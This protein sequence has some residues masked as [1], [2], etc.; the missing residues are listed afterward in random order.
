MGVA[1]LMIVCFHAYWK[2]AFRPWVFFINNYGNTGVDMF[3]F[4]AGFGIAFSL[5]KDPDFYR[6]YKRRIERVLPPYYTALLIQLVLRIIFNGFS[7]EWALKNFIPLGHWAG[8]GATYWY[9]PATLG[10]YLTA[11]LFFSAIKNARFPRLILIVLTLIIGVVIPPISSISSI[12]TVRATAFTIGL[13]IGVLHTMHASRKDRF[14]DLLIIVGFFVLALM[15]AWETPL[16]KL[17][18]FNRLTTGIKRRL[19]KDLTAPLFVLICALGFEV[20]SHTPLRFVNRI[21]SKAGQYS[22]E[23]YIAHL[24]VKPFANNIFHLSKFGQLIAMLVFSYPVALGI[25][26]ASNHFLKLLKKLPLAKH[27]KCKTDLPPS[28]SM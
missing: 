9:I 4:V 23:I 20:L 10:Y 27:N 15:I 28:A 11:P 24:L 5:E 12:A 3:A 22:L 14:L 8:Y 18:L 2:P 25:S 1:A 21:L 16:L 26:W 19:W 6:Y 13:G 17:P 7:V